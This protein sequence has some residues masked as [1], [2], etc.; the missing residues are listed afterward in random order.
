MVAQDD[1]FGSQPQ[2]LPRDHQPLDLIRP[3]ADGAQALVAVHALDRIL[4]H[5]PVAAVDLDGL[6]AHALRYLGAE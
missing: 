3:F 4:P 2:H 5:V 6:V 1:N